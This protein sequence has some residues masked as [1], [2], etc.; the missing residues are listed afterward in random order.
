[1]KLTNIV[2]A[3]LLAL[4]FSAPVLADIYLSPENERRFVE[5]DVARTLEF[6]SVAERRDA[7]KEMLKKIPQERRD[8]ENTI[9]EV[10]AKKVR[11]E[12]YDPLS[13]R[14]PDVLKFINL[15]E[16]VLVELLQTED[17]Q[18]WTAPQV[19]VG[20]PHSQPSKENKTSEKEPYEN[21]LSAPQPGG[22]SPYVTSVA[23][24]LLGLAL[25][26]GVRRKLHSRA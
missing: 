23:V 12:K 14:L 1:M 5:G 6:F 9:K 15:R 11:G 16:T 10:E 24:V 8:L 20:G 26:L 19:Q 18:V 13:Y 17:D 4:F 21:R 25:L 3:I 2:L 7:A 22:T